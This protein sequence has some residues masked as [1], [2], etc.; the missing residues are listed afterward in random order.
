MTPKGSKKQCSKKQEMEAS[1]F[2]SP[3]LRNCHVL[4]VKTV[5]ESTK[6]QETRIETPSLN[7]RSIEEFATIFKQSHKES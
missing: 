4:L 2:L 3:G 5:I 1:S 6:I 7:S